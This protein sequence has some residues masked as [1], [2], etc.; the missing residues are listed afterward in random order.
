MKARHFGP[1]RLLKYFC[2]NFILANFASVFHRILD[3]KRD[4]ISILVPFFLFRLLL[5]NL[6]LP[7]LSFIVSNH[8]KL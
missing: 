7:W 2:P 3:F 1:F 8:Q 6:I 4:W 5:I